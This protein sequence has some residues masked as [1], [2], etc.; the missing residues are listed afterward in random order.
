MLELPFQNDSFDGVLGFLAIT[1]TDY[2]GLKKVITKITDMLKKTGRL[3]V[4][5]N[6]KHSNGFRFK[7]N[8]KIDKYTI[9]KT[10]GLEKGI[11][12]TY[13]E[14]DDIIRLL[15]NYEILK[16]QQIYDYYE[17]IT[18]IHFFVEAEKK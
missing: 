7:S 18:S 9:I 10:H 6:S 2:A 14:H 4:T 1:H 5:F 12:H 17:N 11:P 13:L 15:A 3:Y 16:F 8:V